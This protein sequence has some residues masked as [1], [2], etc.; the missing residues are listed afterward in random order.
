MGTVLMVWSGARHCHTPHFIRGLWGI[1]NR[2]HYVCDHVLR[3]DGPRIRTNPD[4]MARLRSFAWH[5]LYAK[6]VAYIQNIF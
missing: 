5:I 2:N 1:A 3:K 4:H 6:H